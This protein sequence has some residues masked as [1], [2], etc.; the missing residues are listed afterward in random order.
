MAHDVGAGG[1]EDDGPGQK[2]HGRDGGMTYAG[3]HARQRFARDTGAEPRRR[4]SDDGCVIPRQAGEPS[5]LDISVDSLAEEEE[6]LDGDDRQERIRDLLGSIYLRSPIRWQSPIYIESPRSRDAREVSLLE[7]TIMLV[8]V[9]GPARSRLPGLQAATLTRM[10]AKKR[11]SA[12]SKGQRRGVSGDPRRRAE[13]SGEPRP[14]APADPAMREAAY[15]MAG[16]ADPAPWWPR[17][18]QRVLARARTASWPG[19][20]VELEDLTCQL[21]GD[22]L[23]DC[24]RRHGEGHHPAQWLVALA[25]AAG[26]ALR[27]SLSEGC[28][29]GEWRGLWSL[30]C[31]IVL[32]APGAPDDARDGTSLLARRYFPDIK[33]PRTAALAEAGAAARLLDG[34]GLSGP[35]FDGPGFDG[36]P[37]GCRVA[38]TAM[39]ARDDYGSRFLLTAPFTY[40]PEDGGP[41]DGGT[42]WYAWD[43]DACWLDVVVAAGTFASAAGALA[44]WRDAVGPAAS[45]SALAECPPELTAR[46]LAQ[47]LQTGPFAGSVRGDEPLALLREHYRQRRRAREL[48][49]SLGDLPAGTFM[50]DMDQARDEFLSWYAARHGAVAP[51]MAEA[52]D[53]RSPTSGARTRTSTTGDSTPAHRTASSSRRG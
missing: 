20:Y 51:G 37:E 24:L 7:D 2:G 48:F 5:L 42:H 1:R 29:G 15:R 28:E 21:V 18:H 50:V 34:R 17:S 23:G 6:F 26:E 43:V 8:A 47:S 13:Q 25:E 10:S 16:G 45:D 44:D 41:D 11:S 53:T 46:L 49:T 3:K 27:S 9:K 22:E 30:L 36:P 40:G 39:V 32:T 14:A 19:R 33:D 35:G 31:G 4:G 38:G 12:K 52:V